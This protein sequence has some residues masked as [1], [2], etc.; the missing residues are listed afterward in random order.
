MAQ[1]SCLVCQHY[2][3]CFQAPIMLKIIYASVIGGSLVIT[4]EDLTIACDASEYQDNCVLTKNVAKW[5]VGH[6]ISE[7]AFDIYDVL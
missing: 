1:K 2:A 5:N 6:F 4:H 7:C 3:Q